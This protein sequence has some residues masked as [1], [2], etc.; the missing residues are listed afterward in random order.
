FRELIALVHVVRNR[1][2][3]V[4]EFAEQIPAAFARHRGSEQIV[5][6]NLNRFLQEKSRAIRMAHKAQSLELAGLRTVRRFGRR[7]EP[8]LIDTTTMPAVR[9]KIIRMQLQAAPR[10]HKGSRHPV[11]FQ[12]QNPSSVAHGVTDLVWVQHLVWMSPF[13]SACRKDYYM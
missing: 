7:S 8:A 9:I 11:R 3:V 6:G 12:P 4:E 1:P 2:H 10:N 5:P 13:E